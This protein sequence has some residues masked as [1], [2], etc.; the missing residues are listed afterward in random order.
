MSQKPART[1]SFA[2]QTLAFHANWRTLLD[3]MMTRTFIEVCVDSV[4]SALAAAAGGADR[5]E[6]C[7]NL[8]EG[9]LTPSAGLLALVRERLKLP[10]A[11]MIRPR[12]ADFSYSG[13]EF[14]VMRRDLQFAKQAGADMLVLGLLSTDGSVDVARTREL[15]E[16]ARPLP[17]TFHRAFDMV[18]DAE[19]ALEDLI[20]LGV[21]RVLTSGLERTVIE[22]LDLIVALIKQARGRITVVPGGGINE[23]N[24]PRILAATGAREFPVSAS[25]TQESAMTFRNHRVTM[26]RTF[27]P[28]EYSFTHASEARVRTFR[29]LAG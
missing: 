15:I 17:V 22:G 11:V 21:E 9:G 10:I 18:C 1:S 16:L 7:Q 14:E 4:E 13:S 26:G 27:G 25:A 24:L 3:V 2:P 23:R 20:G 5:L 28:A 29:D 19:A 8:C 12:G 6:L